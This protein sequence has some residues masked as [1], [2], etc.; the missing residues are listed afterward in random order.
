MGLAQRFESGDAPDRA[1]AL[2]T[3]RTHLHDTGTT[4]E[5]RHRGPA[6]GGAIPVLEPL[7]PLIPGGVLQR[8]TIVSVGSATHPQTLSHLELALIAGATAGGAWAGVIG[9][10]GFG[11]RAASDL[12]A[13]LSRVLLLDEPGDQW[14]RALAVM[15]GAVDVVLLRPPRQPTATQLRQVASR[16]RAT[17]R[18]RGAVLVTVGPWDG[19]HLRLRTRGADWGGLG[20]GTGHLT[21][22]RVTVS[23]EGRGI[24]GERSAELWLPAADGAVREYVPVDS[25]L[26]APVEPRRPQLRAV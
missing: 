3:L 17:E 26:T 20:D 23:A 5:E 9:C 6:D 7:R 24:G 2:E 16:V 1:A 14:P 21:G 22:R 11:I 15:A 18:Q 10:P 19:A 12:G 25:E 8:G 4:P 13:D